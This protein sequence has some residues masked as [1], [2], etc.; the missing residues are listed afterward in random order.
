MLLTSPTSASAISNTSFFY[1]IYY[2]LGQVRHVGE[3]QSAMYTTMIFVTMGIMMPVGGW[4]SDRL[5]RS[6]GARFGRRVVPMVG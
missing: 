3:S 6:R 1:W 4:I 5:T 2:Y